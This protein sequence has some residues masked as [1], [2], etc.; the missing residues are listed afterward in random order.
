MGVITPDM[1]NKKSHPVKAT[2]VFWLCVFLGP[3]VIFAISYLSYWLGGWENSVFLDLICY[4]LQAI[5]CF[6]AYSLSFHYSKNGIAYR[7]N[8]IICA[9]YMSLCALSGYYTSKI[10]SV[11]SSCISIVVLVFC[12]SLGKNMT[13]ILE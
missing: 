10:P 13:D 12:I 3:F 11:I 4:L 5:S 6:I 8:G 7:V 9:I 2:L 1:G